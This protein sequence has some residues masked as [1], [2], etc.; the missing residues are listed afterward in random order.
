M[1]IYVSIIEQLIQS[2]FILGQFVNEELARMWKEV[3]LWQQWKSMKN[4]THASQSLD[5]E[6]NMG[7]QEYQEQVL[8]TTPL[9]SVC[10]NCNDMHQPSFSIVHYNWNY[11][12]KLQI[13]NLEFCISSEY[14]LCTSPDNK[15]TRLIL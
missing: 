4:F 7:P 9:W 14:L 11:T 2:S 1:F 8:T 15:L 13:T 6:S 3:A 5:L 12:L 10:S